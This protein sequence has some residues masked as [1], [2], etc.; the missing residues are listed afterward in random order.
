MARPWLS[1]EGRPEGAESAD[2]RVRG[3]YL[4]GLFAADGFRTAWAEELGAPPAPGFDW[5]GSVEA[6]LDALAAHVA[7]HL[8]L[9]AI[10]AMAAEV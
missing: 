4:H 9:D 2:G 5:E 6:A 3:T 8:D 1:V 10:W 7:R